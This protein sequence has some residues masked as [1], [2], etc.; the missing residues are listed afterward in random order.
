MRVFV[1]FFLWFV[2]ISLENEQRNGRNGE[3]LTRFAL[4]WCLLDQKCFFN[5]HFFWECWCKNLDLLPIIKNFGAK[6]LISYDFP[7]FYCKISDLKSFFEKS[8]TKML[9]LE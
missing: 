2:S 6:I 7:G 8:G 9:G 4:F 5:D 3:K 1:E